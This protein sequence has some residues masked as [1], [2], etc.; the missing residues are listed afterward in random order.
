MT[1]CGEGATMS[2]MSNVTPICDCTYG[3]NR[4]AHKETPSDVMQAVTARQ[5]EG[6][7]WACCAHHEV[8][9]LFSRA[10]VE[11]KLLSGFV[12]IRCQKPL[13]KPRT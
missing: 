8:R 11:R 3:R 9:S 10:C 13:T 5:S 12:D 6:V 7:T 1:A 4:I 2:S